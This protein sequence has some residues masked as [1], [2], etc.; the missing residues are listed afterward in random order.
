MDEENL[1]AAMLEQLIKYMPEPDVM[2]QLAELKKDYND[3]AEPEQFGVEV[4]TQNRCMLVNYDNM[5]R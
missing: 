3:L 2:G 5:I 1:T 4:R